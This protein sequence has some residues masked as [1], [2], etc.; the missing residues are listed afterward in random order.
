MVNIHHQCQRQ[1][2]AHPPYKASTANLHVLP[3]LWGP[4]KPMP[5][6]NTAQD[7]RLL[8][9]QRMH[10]LTINM[11]VQLWFGDELT[12]IVPTQER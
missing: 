5:V 7:V 8:S 11:I 3:T 4:L 9:I 6:V 10:P 1:W 2:D 12:L